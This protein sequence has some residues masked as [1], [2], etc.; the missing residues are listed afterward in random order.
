[1]DLAREDA[2]EVWEL[3]A[4]KSSIIFWDGRSGTF[5]PLDLPDA[6]AAS[7]ARGRG[8]GKGEVGCNGFVGGW[9]SN[10]V[11]FLCDFEHG[12]ESGVGLL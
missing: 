1:M 9:D 12:V 2:V 8:Q 7:C 11:T 5:G 3:L 4:R 6:F 10:F